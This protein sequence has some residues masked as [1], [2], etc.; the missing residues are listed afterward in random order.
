MH[1]LLD[2]IKPV[3]SWIIKEIELDETL[4]K[5]SR[6]KSVR[7]VQEWLNLHNLGLSI[8][9]DFGRVTQLK[10]KQFQE[11]NGI[12]ATG[13]VDS[14]TFRTLVAPLRRAL[15][16]IP[17]PYGATFN[18]SVLSYAETHLK[19]HPREVGGQNRGPW[20]RLYM[21]GN[22]G[23][24]WAWCAGF[25]TFLIKQAEQTLQMSHVIRGS[26]SCD[27]L[28]A[29]AKN[30]DHFVDE[31]DIASGHTSL[32]SLTPANVFLVRRTD[33]DWTHTG[34]VTRFYDDYFDTIE[35]NTNDDGDREGYE[36]CV[37]SRGYK[38]KDFIRL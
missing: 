3:S 2:D 23:A 31:K 38:N 12:P 19:E 33:T 22:D 25:V 18:S 15:A 24:Q 1:Y 6:G 29:Q 4:H 14:E 9:G 36:V 10:V 21:R 17:V 35:G 13:S 27:T 30:A 16:P 20:V 11:E 32:D 7:R 5:G 34:F 37:R 26:G 28:A 8:D